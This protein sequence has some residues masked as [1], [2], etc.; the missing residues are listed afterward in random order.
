MS[1][2]P[3]PNDV[4]VLVVGAADPDDLDD[5]AQ[6][7]ERRLGREVNIRRIKRETWVDPAPTDTFLTSVRSRPLVELDLA[8]AQE[9]A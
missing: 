8:A 4:D 6:A 9:R 2:G 5:V 3:P 7:A 1:P